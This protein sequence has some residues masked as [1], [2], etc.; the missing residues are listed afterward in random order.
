[1]SE[2]KYITFVKG[3]NRIWANRVPTHIPNQRLPVLFDNHIVKMST[4][5]LNDMRQ[6]PIPLL[7]NY[8]LSDVKNYIDIIESED[9]FELEE[10]ALLLD[11]EYAD[12]EI[13]QYIEEK[14]YEHLEELIAMECHMTKARC[15][16]IIENA[17]ENIT[18]ENRLHLL[19]LHVGDYTKE[20]LI[21]LFEE[22]GWPLPISMFQGKNPTVE[23][24]EGMKHLLEQLE[25]HQYIGSFK[26]VEND[27]TL[28][29]V[30]SKRV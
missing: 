18:F 5:G 14:I 27:E 22:E 12:V 17:G 3:L 26:E 9:W 4:Q 25:H 28:Y 24:S 11:Q 13:N 16:R 29:R 20:E 19:A 8:I 6:R 30:F 1:M 15:S 2:E 10:F 21:T 23:K 7:Q